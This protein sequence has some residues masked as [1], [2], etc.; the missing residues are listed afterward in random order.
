MGHYDTC[1]PE[2]CAVCGQAKGVVWNCGYKTCS[3]YQ[4]W[5]KQNDRYAYD[6]LMTE[7]R[8]V[9]EAAEEQ[10]VTTRQ[11]KRRTNQI[12]QEAKAEFDV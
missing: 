6:K 1:R 8:V 7:L 9:A 11:I 5:L 10:R 3:T 2:N 12:A 4:T